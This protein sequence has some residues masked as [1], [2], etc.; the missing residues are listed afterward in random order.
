MI[1]NIEINKN[2]EKI[3]GRLG[4]KINGKVSISA[5]VIRKNGV[6]EDLGI[7]YD[8]GVKENGKS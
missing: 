8:E 2:V 6:V 1:D 4:S 7:I 5:R 3:N